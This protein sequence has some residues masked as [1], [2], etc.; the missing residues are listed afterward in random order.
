M[1]LTQ[2]HFK[3]FKDE[4]L[5][6][7]KKLGLTNYRFDISSVYDE[8]GGYGAKVTYHNDFDQYIVGIGLNL[9]ANCEQAAEYSFIK[10]NAFHEVLHVLIHRLKE[11]GE[12]RFINEGELYEAEHEI[13]RRLEHLLFN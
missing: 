2:K 4:C 1:K 11:V 6:W 10:K 8:E 12:S 9:H 7:Q 5:K 3:V 13:I